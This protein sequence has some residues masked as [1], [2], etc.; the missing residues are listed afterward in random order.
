MPG[1]AAGVPAPAPGAGAARHLELGD[2]PPAVAE[3]LRFEA[4]APRRLRSEKLPPEVRAE[5]A[6]VWDGIVADVYDELAGLR[7]TKALN[8]KTV[9]RVLNRVWERLRQAE[10][11]LVVTAVYWPLPGDGE[12]KHVATAG[13]GGGAAAAA[14]ELAAY[15][16]FGAGASVAVTSAI[17]GELFETYVAA[18]AR[19]HQYRRAG[20]SPAPDVVVAD[21]AEAVGLRDAMGRRAGVELTREAVSWLDGQVVRRTASRFTR[22]LVPVVGVAVGAGLSGRGVRQVLKLP[23]RP[24]SEHEL[25][26][27]AGDLM[28]DKNAAYAS[29]RARFAA[30][31]PV[32]FPASPDD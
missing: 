17:V 28:A 2:L 30:L 24:P 29:D 10:R 22:G 8:K 25:L 12:W 21:L 5:L 7:R 1:G 13:V 20:R 11:T 15:G 23:L 19:T 16:S 3:R 14:E 4:A 31:P 9:L 18:S 26:R 6:G 32:A 27:M